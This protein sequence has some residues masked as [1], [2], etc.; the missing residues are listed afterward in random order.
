MH[1][2][3]ALLPLLARVF[4]TVRADLYEEC[5]RLYNPRNYVNHLPSLRLPY[6]GD[7]PVPVNYPA[8]IKPSSVVTTKAV[9]V[10]TK[11]VYKNP[12]CVK[13]VKKKSICQPQNGLKKNGNFDKL[14]T[15]EYFVSDGILSSSMGRKSNYQ[16]SNDDNVEEDFNEM[17]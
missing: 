14:V 11:Y 4:I 6:F 13:Y 16:G 1:F 15:K 12:V 10:V 7:I 9:S 17:R 2:A 5:A 8:M 3:F